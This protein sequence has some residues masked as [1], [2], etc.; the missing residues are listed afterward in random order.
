MS[1]ESNDTTADG[2]GDEP[3][4][5][6]IDNKAHAPTCDALD[7]LP[8]GVPLSHHTRAHLV[9]TPGCCDPGLSG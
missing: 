4:V 5:N 7:E 6:P 9:T 2:P 1:A 8:H 3:I